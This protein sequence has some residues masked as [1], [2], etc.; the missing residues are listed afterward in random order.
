[1]AQAERHYNI[2]RRLV[3]APGELREVGAKRLKGAP[4]LLFARRRE[5]RPTL[6]RKNEGLL[7]LMFGDD[8]SEAVLRSLDLVR[9]TVLVPLFVEPDAIR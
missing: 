2:S 3:G 7:W 4:G 5:L 1:M 9:G 6:R 8:L